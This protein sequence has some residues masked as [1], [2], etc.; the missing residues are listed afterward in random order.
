VCGFISGSQN[1]I[2]LIHM[3]F[4]VPVPCH[5]YHC[6]SAVKV[7]VWDGD[8]PRISFIVKTGFHYSGIFAFPIEYENCSFHVFEELF[9]NF[10]GDCI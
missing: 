4:F 5:I 1:S 7:E 8:S 6:C 10:D 3:S 2:P 9:W